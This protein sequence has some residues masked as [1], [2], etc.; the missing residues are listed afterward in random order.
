MTVGIAPLLE[1]SRPRLRRVPVQQEREVILGKLS[2]CLSGGS[3]VIHAKRTKAKS[4]ACDLAKVSLRSPEAL[5]I[6]NRNK[7]THATGHPIRNAP[8][9]AAGVPPG[10]TRRWEVSGD[11]AKD[12]HAH[13]RQIDCF[14]NR[15]SGCADGRGLACPRRPPSCQP[16]SRCRNGRQGPGQQCLCTLNEHT[17]KRADRLWPAVGSKRAGIRAECGGESGA[18]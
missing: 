7:P 12:A 5:P 4:H 6:A 13:V 18:C 3:L 10:S 8:A 14:P 1:I 16:L 2:V 17:N 15:G 11:L 9:L